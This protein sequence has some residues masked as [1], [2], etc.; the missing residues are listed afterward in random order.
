MEE[1]RHA[2]TKT[3][4]M[5]LQRQVEILQ[6]QHVAELKQQITAENT[7]HQQETTLL[8][9]KHE[10][11]L[12]QSQQIAKDATLLT[13]QLKARIDHLQ[14]QHVKAINKTKELT[15][16]LQRRDHEHHD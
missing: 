15:A 1:H 2:I 16:N 8:Q 3:Q 10:T 6:T 14:A 5:E 12:H 9:T 7:W 13:E 11:A 4:N